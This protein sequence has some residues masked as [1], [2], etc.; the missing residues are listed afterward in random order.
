MGF[1]I[2]QQQPQQEQQHKQQQPQQQSMAPVPQSSPFAALAQAPQPQLTASSSLEQLLA[3]QCTAMYFACIVL[4]H[5][6]A[7]HADFA[8]CSTADTKHA[9]RRTDHTNAAFTNRRR[10]QPGRVRTA[11]R[12]AAVCCAI[13]Q[14]GP[15]AAAPAGCHASGRR[16]TAGLCWPKG[17]GVHGKC[18]STFPAAAP[19]T[20]TALQHGR[21]VPGV[22]TS[23]VSTVNDKQASYRAR[24]VALLHILS[25][26]FIS[27][28]LLSDC[29]SAGGWPAWWPAG[30]LWR[31][32]PT[33]AAA[34]AAGAAVAASHAAACAHSG[35]AG[36]PRRRR[37][38]VSAGSTSSIA[39]CPACHR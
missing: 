10:C 11:A 33:A 1:S 3:G 37:W 39:R 35:R 27:G 22:R 16:P 6:T 15:R 9:S 8:N 14:R 30:Q 28:L 29:T 31:A 38:H 7:G 23:H 13:Q 21:L 36:E 24:A 18:G 19:A 25:Q 26:G 17:A 34:A 20:A 12:H 2:Q 32:A 5:R 4:C